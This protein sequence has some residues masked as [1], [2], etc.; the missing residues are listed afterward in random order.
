MSERFAVTQTSDERRASSPWQVG[1][2]RE[3]G[4]RVRR[5]FPSK[6]AAQQEAAKLNAEANRTG[7]L[8]RLTDAQRIEAEKCFALLEPYGVSLIA[9]VEHHVAHLKAT[10][11]SCTV[12]EAVAEMLE[13]KRVLGKSAR[14]IAEAK[15]QL[16]RLIEAM[17]DRKVSSVTARDLREWLAARKLKPVSYNNARCYLGI[18]W[19][20]C[21]RC[22]YTE[23]NPVKK[24]VGATEPSLRPGILTPAA[25]RALIAVAREHQPCTLPLILI[26]AFAGLRASEAQRL[27]WEQVKLDRGIIDL[28]ADETKTGHRRLVTIRPNLAAFLATMER[29]DGLVCA[30]YQRHLPAL[31]PLLAQKGHKWPSNALRHSFASYHLADC[32]DA[33]KTALQLG[34]DS[35]KQLFEHYR[36]VVT[37]EEAAK[38]WEIGL[39]SI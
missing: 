28:N 12:A 32:E 26:Q 25:M 7:L 20:F 14:Y 18:L 30:G 9:A 39:V 19:A 11:V 33:A 37:P 34:H 4:T 29:G 8:G 35:T 2:Y 6:F 36:E 17:G 16:Q 31:R 21:V 22:E 24:I 10:K 38:W 3:D 27:R 5:Y 1:G 13:E 15:H 23:E